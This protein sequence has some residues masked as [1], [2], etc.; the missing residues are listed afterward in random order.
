MSRRPAI[1]EASP[2]DAHAVSAATAADVSAM[3]ARVDL[4]RLLLVSDAPLS[5]QGLG[6][7]RTLVSLFEDYPTDRF[8]LYTRG[9]PGGRDAAHG[10]VVHRSTPFPQR[11]VRPILTRFAHVG[12]VAAFHRALTTLDFTIRAWTP[13]AGL[14]AIRQFDPEVVLICP[15]SPVDLL[16]GHKV[17]TRLGRPFVVYFMDDWP[18]V[19]SQRWLGGDIQS[20][21]RD[22]LRDAD[23]WIMI[24]DALTNRLRGRY[25]TTQDRILVA[26]NPVGFDDGQEPDFTVRGG[27]FRIAYAGSI[28]PMHHDAVALVAEGVARLRS[29]GEDVE[30]VVHCPEQF[31]H[32][33]GEWLD[34][35]GVRYGGFVQHADLTAAL[36]QADLLLVASSFKPEFAPYAHGSVQTKVTDYMRTGRTIMSVGPAGCACNLF[37]ERW[38]CGLVSTA[39]TADAMAADL[40]GALRD[41]GAHVALARTAYETARRHFERRAVV[42]TMQNFLSEV[43]LRTHRAA[44][45]TVRSPGP[46]V[47]A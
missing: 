15:N 36:Q 27:T 3:P 20:V 26:H 38:N 29:E 2:P 11:H 23:A 28:W 40:R 34:S 25:G 33:Y 1:S 7:D 21:V 9:R 5:R 31:W 4:P 30:F 13:P 41:R 17:A 47:D 8:L 42:R 14:P 46:P 35:R 10:D 19:V 43:A 44:A 32:Q 16:E 39:P 45:S 18:A 6:I 37:V 22:V 12:P 24:S